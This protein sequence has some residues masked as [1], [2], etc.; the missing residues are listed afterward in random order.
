MWV[1]AVDNVPSELCCTSLID[2]VKPS[3]VAEFR[4]IAFNKYGAGKPSRA[5]PN[6][7]MPQQ[8]PAAAPRNVGASAR[9]S[10]SVMVQWQPPEAE[11]WNGEILGYLVR[12]RLAGYVTEWKVVNISNH[13]SRNALLEPLITWREYE[14]QV[15][16]YNER[17][18]GVYSEPIEV[19]FWS[20]L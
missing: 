9:S 5:S 11:Q 15:A 7:T 17:G 13:L 4:V 6:I 12:Y 14:I 16:A 8:P 3:A 19:N 18:C 10:S 20:K 1:P 2:N